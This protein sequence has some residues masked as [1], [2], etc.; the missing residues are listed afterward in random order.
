MKWPLPLLYPKL[1][2]IQIRYRESLLYEGIT[3]STI[4]DGD[5][6]LDGDSIHGYSS[7]MGR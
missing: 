2:Y 4:P 7:D 5:P 3:S 1:C 6:W